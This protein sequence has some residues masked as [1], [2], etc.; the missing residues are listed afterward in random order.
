MRQGR[1]QRDPHSGLKFGEAF[2][3]LLA[4]T[5]ISS[6]DRNS[7]THHMSR[8]VVPSTHVYG[9]AMK[10]ATA[11][12][13]MGASLADPT[14]TP[15]LADVVT[16]YGLDWQALG[17][18]AGERPVGQLVALPEAGLAVP[19]YV[20]FTAGSTVAQLVP[21]GLDPATVLADDDNI[22]LPLLPGTE[23]VIPAAEHAQPADGLSAGEL[24]EAFGV[25]LASLTTANMDRPA[26]L[27]P[28]F[29]FSAQGIEVEVPATGEPGADATLDDIAT[30]LGQGEIPLQ[31]V[32]SWRFDRQK[33]PHWVVV[34]AVDDACVHIHD[35]F[36]DR[37]EGRAPIDCIRIPV[38]R[39]DFERMSRYGRAGLRA[40]LFIS[41]L[42]T[43]GS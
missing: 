40:T 26:L 21:T 28:G 30:A 5:K 16:R 32:S 13:L 8:A 34:V 25:T 18:A 35:P 23:L 14:V 19:D 3:G 27:A 2:S 37:D 36:V 31:L 9:R 29:V 38:P 42:P 12:A 17:L 41:S 11:A 7:L 33:A 15:T 39:R 10:T 24:A 6:N 43:P 4:A 1:Q 20:V 22:V